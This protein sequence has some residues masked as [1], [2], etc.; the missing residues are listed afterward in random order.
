M[1]K[2]HFKFTLIFEEL[3]E[4]YTASHLYSGVRLHF[5]DNLLSSV[6]GLIDNKK[7]CNRD[8]YRSTTCPDLSGELHSEK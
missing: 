8:P 6:M 4:I 7:N 5:S 3:L 2:I 1:A